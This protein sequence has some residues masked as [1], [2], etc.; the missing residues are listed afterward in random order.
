MGGFPNARVRPDWGVVQLTGRQRS[1]FSCL[2]L[3]GFTLAGQAGNNFEGAGMPQLLC[4][5]TQE[6]EMPLWAWSVEHVVS[7]LGEPGKVVTR[8]GLGHRGHW[9]TVLHSTRL[10][11][12]HICTAHQTCSKS[13][14]KP[15]LAHGSQEERRPPPAMFLHRPLLTKH[16][17]LLNCQGKCLRRPI[18]DHDQVL[19]S[20]FVTER[21]WID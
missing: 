16:S 2:D 15:N 12:L 1:L 19:K 8:P 14:K 9:R 5:C 6:F 17:I 21:Q 11:V 10:D 13:K 20:E 18:H 3:S 4:V 7:V